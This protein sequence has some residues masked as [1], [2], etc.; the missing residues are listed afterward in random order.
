MNCIAFKNSKFKKHN[1]YSSF[2]DNI[3]GA[4]LA[5]VQLRSEY[6]KGVRFM[7]CYWYLQQI[8]LDCSVEENLDKSGRKPKKIWV[9]Q[10]NGFYNRSMAKVL[11]YLVQ[12]IS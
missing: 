12:S 6:N 8:C 9:D 11:K 1:I 10:G 4:A 7:L 5:D 3:W 2:W